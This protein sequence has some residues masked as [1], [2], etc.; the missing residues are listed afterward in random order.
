MPRRQPP[1]EDIMQTATMQPHLAGLPAL[2]LMLRFTRDPLE[3]VET[4]NARYGDRALTR[5]PGED[6]L[7]LSR[8]DDIGAVLLKYADATH[9]SGTAQR[10]TVILGEG[11]LISEGDLWRTRRRLAAPSLKRKHIASY[12]D[13]MVRHADVLADRLLQ[14][15]TRADL[16][17]DMMDVTLRIVVECLLGSDLPGEVEAVDAAMQQ[18]MQG[19]EKL[20]HSPLRLLPG[21]WPSRANWQLHQGRKRLDRILHAV[22][23]AR[24]ANPEGDDLLARLIQAQVTEGVELS[25]TAL[26]DEVAT[27][28][29][30]G[31]ET[32]ALTLTYALI[33]LARHPEVRAQIEDE[34]DGLTGPPTVNDLKHLTLTGAVIDEALRLYPPAW[35]MGREATRDLPDFPAGPVKKGTQLILL[36]W[37]THRDPRWWSEPLAFRPER[38][39]NGVSRPRYCY[40]P[41]G[42]GPRVCIGNHFA[43]MEAILVLAALT[44]RLRLQIPEDYEVRHRPSITLRLADALPARVQARR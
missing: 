30:A 35:V 28:F 9:N 25:N 33:L 5:L 24:R 38:W 39:L 6:L 16:Q 1:F 17:T 23:A 41:F 26:R 19:F 40:L 36:P 2:R 15:P 4:L 8:P 10:L 34:V 14:A 31:H 7:L 3:A 11:L 29:L 12:A 18:V 32:T 42:A 27:M 21:W 43:R 44:R 37:V 22:I 20:A 13:A